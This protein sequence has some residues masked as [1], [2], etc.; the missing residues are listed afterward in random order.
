LSIYFYVFWWDWVFN[1]GL[2]AFEAGTLLL[3]PHFQ[4]ILLWL[5]WR[6]GSHELGAQAVLKLQSLWSQ[7]PKWLGLQVWVTGSAQLVCA[8]YWFIYFNLCFSGRD[9]IFK[10]TIAIWAGDV[11]R[12]VECLLCK[13]EA[14]SSNPSLRKKKDTK[15]LN[16]T[17]NLLHTSTNTH[18]IN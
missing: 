8:F 2:Q 14:L 4:S 6:W 3:E 16:C 13:R 11:A 17:V 10:I 18:T 7:P 9:P 1:S 15:D 12:A 5:F